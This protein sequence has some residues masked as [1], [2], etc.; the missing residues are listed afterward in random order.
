[1]TTSHCPSSSSVHLIL[2]VRAG[3]H[4]YGTNIA[5]SDIDRRGIFTADEFSFITRSNYIDEIEGKHPDDY[6]F[7]EL[8]K[9]MNLLSAQNPNIMEILWTQNND[10]LHLTPAGE[11]L[12][13]YRQELLS[14]EVARTYVEYAMSQIRRI[15]GHNKMINKPQPTTAPQI[16]DFTKIKYNLTDKAEYNKA[17]PEE[18]FVIFKSSEDLWLAFSIEKFRSALPQVKAP[19]DKLFDEKGVPRSRDRSELDRLKALGVKPDILFNINMALYKTQ[20]DEWRQYWDWVK[21]RNPSRSEL[22]QQFGYDTK[23]AMHTI[24]LLRSGLEIIKNKKVLVKRSDAAE[25]LSIRAGAWSYE[26]LLAEAQTIQNQI[27]ECL[28]T[29][30]LPKVVDKNLLAQ[31]H[32]DVYKAAW[33]EIKNSVSLSPKA[34]VHPG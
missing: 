1:M 18:G 6:R 32:F 22:E 10:I 15:K 13:S 31:I 8:N 20:F 30:T 2:E 7:Y 26:K 33:L 17:L 3:S 25:L 27:Q 9:F 12:Q 34:R 14:Q 24:R 5:S 21:N 11:L 16:K 23:H 4:A 19:S 29:T 28:V